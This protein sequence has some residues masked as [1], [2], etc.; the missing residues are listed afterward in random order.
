MAHFANSPGGTV[1]YPRGMTLERKLVFAL[2]LSI[3]AVFVVNA[4]VSVA[5]SLERST[6][7][8]FAHVR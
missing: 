4:A 2:T 6:E 5:M 1:I 7:R 8:M 3:A